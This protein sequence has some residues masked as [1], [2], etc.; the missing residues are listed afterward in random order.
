MSAFK[1]VEGGLSE[2]YNIFRDFELCSCK[3]TNTRL[4]GVVAVHAEWKSLE[5]SRYRIHQFI[6]LDFS[7]LGPD[8]YHEVI[9]DRARR[10]NN[11]EWA[12]W[13]EMSQPLGG[14]LV[15]LD[16]TDLYMLAQASINKMKNDPGAGDPVDREE[17]RVACIRIRLMLEALEETGKIQNDR[18]VTDVV[19]KLSPNR[20]SKAETINYF[21]M[22]M[23]DRDVDAAMSLSTIEEKK[24]LASPL[25]GRGIKM[26]MKAKTRDAETD[27]VP[28]PENGAR[29]C[30]VATEA[31]TDAGS[32]YFI[33]E[34]GIDLVLQG[35]VWKVWRCESSRG[36]HIS[37]VEA[38][39]QM[40]RPEYITLFRI[41]GDVENLDQFRFS[42][43]SASTPIQM[44]NGT[45]YVK[46]NDDNS[47]VD[48]YKYLMN[49]DLY[50][51]Y[52][53][54]HQGELVVMSPELF[55]ISMMELDIMSSVMAGSIHL[56]KRYKSA[57]QIFQSFAQIPGAFFAEAVED[58]EA[59]PGDKGP[60]DK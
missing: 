1:V 27:D 20:L 42:M 41:D 40:D 30:S 12:I 7:E 58:P 54:T 17:Y 33:Y 52:L 16:A 14:T 29:Y 57:S 53:F 25:M 48:S 24:L 47:Y 21:V 46:Y 8:G 45:M 56:V 32:G 6:H 10:L 49:D 51:A 9:P 35:G 38:S 15:D 26:L 59:D 28:V 31:L 11:S 13:K 60:D 23:V 36:M 5:N 18:P 4:M 43:M 39:M 44:P 37:S 22:R 3:G 2:Y 34:I 50:G 19:K 55:H